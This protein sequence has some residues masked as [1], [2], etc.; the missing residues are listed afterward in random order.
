MARITFKS[1]YV[2]IVI[3]RK[4]S[5]LLSWVVD[6]FCMNKRK[7]MIDK[8][9]YNTLK[10]GENA[11]SYESQLKLKRFMKKMFISSASTMAS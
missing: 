3:D 5:Y 4:K 8:L 11:F 2:D 6:C 7:A 9:F 1:N 10:C